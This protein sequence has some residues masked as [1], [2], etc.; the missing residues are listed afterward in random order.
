M[1]PPT[2]FSQHVVYPGRVITVVREV[3]RINARQIVRE[4]VNHPGSVAIVPFV[5]PTQIV[6]V[7]QYRRAVQRTL[8]ELPAGTLRPGE[9]TRTCARRELE[10][11]T[12]FSAKRLRKLCTFYPSPGILSE[13]MTLFVAE[14]LTKGKANPDVDESI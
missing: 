11:E 12:G 6:L 2:V 9:D 5:S 13:Q 3:L 10:E 4:V 7:R 14:Q 1:T 8:L